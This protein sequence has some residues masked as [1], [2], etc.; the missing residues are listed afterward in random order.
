MLE[1]PIAK[2]FFSFSVSEY[3]LSRRGTWRKTAKVWEQPM[4]LAKTPLTNAAA[5]G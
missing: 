1:S 3:T 5:K 2:A 4:A